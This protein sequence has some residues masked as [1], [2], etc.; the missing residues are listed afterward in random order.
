MQRLTIFRNYKR[1]RV[2]LALAVMSIAVATAF[3][4]LISIVDGRVRLADFISLVFLIL[5]L[6]GVIAATVALR[7][8]LEG[9]DG[10]VFGSISKEEGACRV[11]ATSYSYLI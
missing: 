6:Y 3:A 8:L 4:G 9:S 10:S 11:R 1:P 5:V 7:W 2:I